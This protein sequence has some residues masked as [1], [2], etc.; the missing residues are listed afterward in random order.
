MDGIELEIEVRRKL[1]MP[2]RVMAMAGLQPGDRVQ[3]QGRR[4]RRLV[5]IPMADL[6]E[7]Y[8]G[9]VPG[10]SAAADLPEQRA[11]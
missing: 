11:E 4:D 2:S 9:S 8:T 10:L 7:K 3:V 6:V 5:V 1:G